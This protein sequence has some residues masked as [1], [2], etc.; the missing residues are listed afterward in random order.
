MYKG[1]NVDCYIS[2]TTIQ[3]PKYK[4]KDLTLIIIYRVGEEDNPMYLLTDMK[5]KNKDEV[6]KNI[7]KCT[8]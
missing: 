5:V 6:I 3:F 8:C 7:Q 2:Y 1:E 4:E